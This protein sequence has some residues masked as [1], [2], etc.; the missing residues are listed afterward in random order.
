[1]NRY[2]RKKS[3]HEHLAFRVAFIVLV[4]TAGIVLLQE[5]THRVVDPSRIAWPVG[6]PPRS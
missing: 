3:L 2:S 1:M 4:V 6:G 5:C